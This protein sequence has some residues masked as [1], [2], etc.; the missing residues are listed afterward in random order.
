MRNACYVTYLREQ[1]YYCTNN[2][3]TDYNFKGDDAAIWDACS[4]KATYKNRPAGKPFFAIFNL[5]VSHESSLFPGVIA[6]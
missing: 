4:G 3:K 1:G 6:A 5:T 2:S